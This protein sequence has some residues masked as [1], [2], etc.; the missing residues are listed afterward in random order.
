MGSDDRELPEIRVTLNLASSYKT[1]KTCRIK[2]KYKKQ[3]NR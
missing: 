1:R 3:V 2:G